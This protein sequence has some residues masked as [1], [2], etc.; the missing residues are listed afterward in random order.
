MVGYSVNAKII[1]GDSVI[2]STPLVLRNSSGETV[3]KTIESLCGKWQDYIY[4]P[5]NKLQ[6][7]N[8]NYEVWTD[9]GWSKIKRVIKHKTSKKIYEVFTSNSCVTVTEDHSLLNRESTKIKPSECNIGTELLMSYPET[10]FMELTNMNI[11][12]SKWI[13]NK[14]EFVF[15]TQLEA[16]EFYH[17]MKR[18]NIKSNGIAL[19]KIDDKYVL[20]QC[21]IPDY[22]IGDEI[23][24]SIPMEPDV[25][26]GNQS[27]VPIDPKTCVEFKLIDRNPIIEN[28]IVKITEI[29]YS[30]EID[31]YDLETEN[32][33]FQAGIGE[34][35]V[36]N[37]DSV[38]YTIGAKE[39]KTGI[40]LDDKT[41]LIKSIKMGI[42]ASIFITTLLPN[43]MAQEY[44][45]CMHPLVLQGKKRYVGNLYEKSVDSYKQKSMGIELKR[46]DNANIVKMVSIGI[47]DAI[48]NKRQPLLAY[49]FV[50]DLL[51]KVIRGDF[52]MN[53][54]I[55]SKSLKGNSMCASERTIEA[56]KPKEQRS[57]VDRTRMV[58]AVLAD[59]IADRDYGNRPL[60]NDR[61]QYIYIETEFEPE[62]QGERVETPEYISEK[63]LKIDYLFYITNQIMKPSLKFLDLIATNACDLF[64][65][66]I[67]REQNR[68]N[69]IMPTVYYTAE[70]GESKIDDFIDKNIKSDNNIVFHKRKGAVKKK[71]QIID[72]VSDNTDSRKLLNIF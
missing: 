46:R 50:R 58:H 33:H 20:Y 65:D 5:T 7:T 10:K 35:I 3:I 40:I 32:H 16:Q 53:A 55:I 63:K 38:F 69:N 34:I 2:G 29:L 39:N 1:Y 47:I 62:L 13:H 43:G 18:F 12:L 70:F 45:K 56:Q 28:K 23:S 30:G 15:D 61:I 48:L 72:D 9:Q 25:E 66:Y 31:V 37:T 57:Y 64:K 4:G 27:I 14:N 26:C 24:K 8:V 21:Y 49:E 52:N 41:A 42:W 6:D 17:V 19:K 68:K 71:K 11:S 44:E 67:V 59:R 51:K 22:I 60:S 36:H 54:F